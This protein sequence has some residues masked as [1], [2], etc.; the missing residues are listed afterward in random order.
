MDVVLV[1]SGVT[2]AREWDGVRPLLE[3]PH[4]TVTATL[5]QSRPLVDIVLDAIPGERAALIGTSF[6]GR[7]VLEAAASAPERAEAVVA[8]GTNPFEW[9]DDVKAVGA[10]EEA[11]YEE[12]R[13]DDAAEVMVRAWLVGPHRSEDDVPGELRE[14]V[15]A[16]QRGIYEL[17]EEPQRGAFEPENVRTRM[18]FVRG[19]LDWPDIARAA[20][21]FPQAQQAVI[22]GAAHLPT[23]ERPDEVA[24]LIREFLEA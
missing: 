8:I 20:E 17:D 11:L 14:L 22:E 6:G 10:E 2:D 18:L 23:L 4:R 16:M 3:P 15:F 12:G 19:E 5:W 24:R 1:H 7:A 13:L 21:R 9:S